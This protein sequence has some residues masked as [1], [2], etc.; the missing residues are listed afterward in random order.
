VR[1]VSASDGLLRYFRRYCG[2]RLWTPS[3]LRDSRLG[4]VNPSASKLRG[5]RRRWSLITHH[6]S[7]FDGRLRS[8]RP[9]ISAIHCANPGATLLTAITRRSLICSIHGSWPLTTYVACSLDWK[10]K[11]ETFP[12][13]A[14]VL[15]M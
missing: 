9:Y 10:S 13:C 4:G 7:L 15:L 14:Q 1:Q 11:D 12:C 6:V 8:S 5:A 3:A 2:P